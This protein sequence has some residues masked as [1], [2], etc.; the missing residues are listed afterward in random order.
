MMM[1]NAG[2][3]SWEEQ[4]EYGHQGGRCKAQA[5]HRY[6][7]PCAIFGLPMYECFVQCMHARGRQAHR[8]AMVR[9]AG[10]GW[11]GCDMCHRISACA[12][13]NVRTHL[14]GGQSRSR[15]AHY[16]CTRTAFQVIALM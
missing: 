13:V 5:F 9:G 14:T 16:P 7:L 4:E 3:A 8:L 11:L 10:G 2:D 1:L 6:S 12:D 15:A